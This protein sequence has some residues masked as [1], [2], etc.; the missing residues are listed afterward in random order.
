M[1]KNG[2]RITTF[3]CRAQVGE[4]PATGRRKEAI[5]SDLSRE[6]LRTKQGGRRDA[7][8]VVSCCVGGPGRQ[9]NSTSIPL[10]KP[11]WVSSSRAVL[12]IS[13]VVDTGSEA[14]G[15]KADELVSLDPEIA[16][17]PAGL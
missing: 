2:G 14:G 5:G 3:E 8:F 17:L 12:A 7:S 13:L 10:N 9:I 16:V 4:R 6:M 15:D 11:S 1:V